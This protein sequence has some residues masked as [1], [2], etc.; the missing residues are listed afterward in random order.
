VQR[1][2]KMISH[3]RRLFTSADGVILVQTTTGGS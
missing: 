3:H 1:F 2:P